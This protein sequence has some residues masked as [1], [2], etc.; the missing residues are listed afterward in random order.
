MEFVV[1]FSYQGNLLFYKITELEKDRY[2]ALL[3]NEVD[4]NAE[5]PEELLI[6]KK[7]GR[8]VCDPPHD[9]ILQSIIHAIQ[10]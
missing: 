3:Q 10:I 5:V 8:F 6:S 4:K 7:E 2:R 1:V 9:A